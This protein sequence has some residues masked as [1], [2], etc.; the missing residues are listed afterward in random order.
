MRYRLDR[1]SQFAALLLTVVACGSSSPAAPSIP[2]GATRVL[3]IGNSLTYVNGLPGMFVALAK[4]G[5]DQNVYAET[6]AFPDYALEDHWA[7]GTARRTL[8]EHPW[9][10]VVMQ[11]GSSALPESQVNLRT[12]SLQFAPL[13][14]AAGATPVMYMVWPFASRTFDFPGVLQSYRNAASAINGIFAPA[15]DGW[16]A[17]G[18]LNALYSADGLHPTVQGTYIAALV[19]LERI[20]GI[21]PDQLPATIPGSSISESEVRALQQAARRALDRNDARPVAAA[22]M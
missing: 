2:V 20:R 18:D 15:G 4:L 12:W 11:Q 8:A 14:R 21:R 5:G 17:F 22:P 13:I 1:I 16:T 6:V 7:Q 10:F 9:E 19:L 3:F